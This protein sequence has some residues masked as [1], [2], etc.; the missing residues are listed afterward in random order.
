MIKEDKISNLM[1]RITYKQHKALKYKALKQDTTVSKLIRELIDGSLNGK[2]IP[3]PKQV[4][5][6]PDNIPDNETMELPFGEKPKEPDSGN[7]PEIVR[8]ALEETKEEDIGPTFPSPEAERDSIIINMKKSGIGWSKIATALN[9]NDKGFRRPNGKKW[10]SN[11]VRNKY[12]SLTK[13]K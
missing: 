8:Q 2:I 13:N 9:E 10:D 5:T 12:D 6:K 1:V 7:K 4:K 11:S 3:T